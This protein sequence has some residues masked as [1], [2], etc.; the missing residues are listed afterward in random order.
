[1][2][3]QNKRR[4]PYSDVGLMIAVSVF[5]VMIVK[6]L[7]FSVTTISIGWIVL[8]GIYFFLSYKY[9]SE[10]KIIKHSTTAFILLSLLLFVSIIFLDTNVKPKMH[11]FEGAKKDTLTE[12]EFK[13]KKDP[14][15]PE[16][17]EQDEDENDTLAI[18]PDSVNAFE[19]PES[20][21]LNNTEPSE[22]INEEAEETQDS[23]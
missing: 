1:M 23:Y 18:V 21:S 9:N 12:E 6:C 8:C 10:D 15:I 3:E 19:N 17:I 20:E 4:N 13:M 11:A 2:S 14:T 16:E 5:I 7:L 22:Q